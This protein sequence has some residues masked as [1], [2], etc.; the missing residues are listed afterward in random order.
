[1]SKASPRPVIGS[2]DANPRPPPPSLRARPSLLLS[3]LP[4]ATRVKVFNSTI[5]RKAHNTPATGTARTPENTGPVARAHNDN[6]PATGAKRVLLEMG[7][8]A[9]RLS[10]GRCQIV[11]VWRP[12]AYAAV[13]APLA[14]VDF[15]SL[16]GADLVATDLILSNEGNRRGENYSL[17]HNG[18][19]KWY[20]LSEQLPAEAVVFK[21]YD[22]L[23]VEGVSQLT[24]HSAFV[25]PN[26][27][28]DAKP[29]QSIE[30]RCLVFY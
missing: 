2:Q 6:T 15:R 19:Q 7:A 22:S 25:N 20:F 10:K 3:T 14:Y 28:A 24:P 12:L 30:V 1:M 9:E 23:V 29:R 26:A 21:I 8:E 5:R 4:G 16:D 11:N 27:P 18:A 17:R 13:D